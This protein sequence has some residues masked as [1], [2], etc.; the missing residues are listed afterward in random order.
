MPAGD[1]R[2]VTSD[3]DTFW[4]GRNTKFSSE[5]QRIWFERMRDKGWTVPDW[6]K[7]YGGGGL[8]GAEHKVLR[9][10]M[11]AIGARSAA[12]ELRHL[13]ART[14]TARN[15]ATRRRR[16]SICRRSLRA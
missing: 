3:A 2:A 4:G 13:D 5:P 15:T 1:A 12:V 10:E 9:E 16:R 11:A 7:E 6:P 14:G 8:D